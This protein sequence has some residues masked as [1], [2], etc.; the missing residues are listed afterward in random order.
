MVTFLVT[1]L[2]V[3]GGRRSAAVVIYVSRVHVASVD[4]SLLLLFTT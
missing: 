1:Y 3:R 4:P 2:S